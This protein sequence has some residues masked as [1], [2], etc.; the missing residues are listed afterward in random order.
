MRKALLYAV[1]YFAKRF[2]S[3]RDDDPIPPDTAVLMPEH[4]NR[5]HRL[6]ERDVT[7]VVKVDVDAEFYSLAVDGINVV[8]EI[9]EP[10]R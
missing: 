8:A 7:V 2:A 6:L 9:P 10:G 1:Q 3:F 5:M 4:C